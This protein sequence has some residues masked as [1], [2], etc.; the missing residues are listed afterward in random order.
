MGLDAKIARCGAWKARGTRLYA[1]GR[2]RRAE[3][4]GQWPRVCRLQE[5]RGRRRRAEVRA[6]NGSGSVRV[7]SGRGG[8]VSPPGVGSPRYHSA[9]LQRS[10]PSRARPAAARRGGVRHTRHALG[11]KAVTRGGWW[12]VLVV[13]VLCTRPI[14]ARHARRSIGRLGGDTPQ[15]E[16][17]GSCRNGAG[18]KRFNF[19][20]LYYSTIHYIA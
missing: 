12:V 18:G 11:A 6:R 13:A 20:L 10:R 2:L 1:A 17:S 8:C 15:V 9:E 19:V 16:R 4:T 3:V 7:A 5:W 14:R